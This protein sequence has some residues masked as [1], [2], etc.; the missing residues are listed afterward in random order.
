MESSYRMVLI[1][2]LE[3]LLEHPYIAYRVCHYG[4]Y[5]PMQLGDKIRASIDLLSNPETTREKVL[6]NKEL[7]IFLFQLCRACTELW[8]KSHTELGLYFY[9]ACTI[10]NY[11][12][13]ELFN[14]VDKICILL[15][16]DL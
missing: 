3:K 12:P 14:K 4:Q 10:L 8:S 15:Q 11:T 2:L 13:I 16:K 1:A 7:A 9:S 6:E 5:Y